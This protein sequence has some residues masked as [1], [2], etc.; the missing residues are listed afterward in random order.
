MSTTAA[1]LGPHQTFETDEGRTVVSYFD[2]GPTSRASNGTEEKALLFLAG[3][4][5]LMRSWSPVLLQGLAA[6]QRVI[7]MDYPG[8][9]ESKVSNSTDNPLPQYTIEWMAD[10]AMKL[11]E[12]L[13]LDQGQTSVLGRSMGSMVALQ[14]AVAHG[15]R[16]DKIIPVSNVVLN[17]G[18]RSAE[19]FTAAKTSLDQTKV[20]R[21]VLFLLGQGRPRFTLPF[22][23][24]IPDIL[25]PH[26]RVRC[27]A[28]G[29]LQGGVHK[30][31]PQG[32]KAFLQDLVKNYNAPAD[33]TQSIRQHK[34]NPELPIDQK[35]CAC[36]SRGTGGCLIAALI[37][38]S[39]LTLRSPPT[40]DTTA[41]VSN[42]IYLANLIKDFRW[43]LFKK[44]GHAVTDECV[45]WTCNHH[46]PMTLLTN[47]VP[48]SPLT[49]TLYLQ[50]YRLHR[51]E[52]PSLPIRYWHR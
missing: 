11:L 52:H 5:S 3:L 27:R 25:S 48:H 12:S 38:S 10:T 24:S 15:F 18:P 29:L 43:Q 47:D 37:F 49:H 9:G 41:L 22:T 31:V 44:A 23:A 6:N 35:P 51:F 42:L 13:S 1:F 46:A 28:M 50:V 33:R 16:L 19:L 36:D 30:D 45:A 21:H 39:S 2:F 7:I 40:Q 17:T 20:C 14:M 34:S 4:G 26:V 8:Q 32:R